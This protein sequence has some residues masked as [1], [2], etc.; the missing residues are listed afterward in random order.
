MPG[1][2]HRI[3]AAVSTT[4]WTTG[5]RCSAMRI[6]TR[7]AASGR[8]ADA[9]SLLSVG[10]FGL[11]TAANYALSGLIDWMIAALFTAGGLIGGFFGMRAAV[12]LAKNRRVLTSIFA[13]V[14]FAV[15]IYMLIRTGLPLWDAMFPKT[16][17]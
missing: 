13:A 9:S 3:S 17:A 12:H 6:G 5:W 14:I 4:P 2:A 11:T 7:S 10:A 15:A 1:T 16:N 8:D